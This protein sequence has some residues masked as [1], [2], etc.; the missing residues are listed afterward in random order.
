MYSNLHF[1]IYQN[2]QLTSPPFGIPT[3]AAA[4]C[5]SFDY[6]M[7]ANSKT[8]TLSLGLFD[9]DNRNTSRVVWSA[10]GVSVDRWAYGEVQIDPTH[11]P[12]S[13]RDLEIKFYDSDSIFLLLP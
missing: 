11:A 3:G 5:F 12:Y 8:T 2:Y 6:Y 4:V 9:G 7:M 10:A 13:V 1:F